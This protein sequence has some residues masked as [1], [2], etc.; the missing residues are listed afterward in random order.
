LKAELDHLKRLQEDCVS[1]QKSLAIIQSAQRIL[2]LYTADERK[3]LFREY[4]GLKRGVRAPNG[5]IGQA[6]DA[7]MIFRQDHADLATIGDVLEQL[8]GVDLEKLQLRL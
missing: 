3:Q 6:F 2:A 7:L 4:D 1:I 8:D 5:N